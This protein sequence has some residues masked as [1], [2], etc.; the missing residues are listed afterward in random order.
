[1]RDAPWAVFS[2]LFTRCAAV[3]QGGRPAACA[4]GQRAAF[5]GRFREPSSAMPS[6]T[7]NQSL[8]LAGSFRVPGDK[9][10][11]HRALMLASLAAGESTVEGLL[12]GEDVMRTAAALRA[13]GAEIVR[14]PDGRWHVWG[15]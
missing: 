4:T 13:L 1:M 14:G 2:E 11:S 7:A 9:S 15:R 12:E 10:I 6:V 3:L 8:G 5:Q